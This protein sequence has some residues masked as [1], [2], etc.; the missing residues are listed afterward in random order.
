MSKSLIYNNLL[1]D[2]TSI[3]HEYN[4]I[5]RHYKLE[6]FIENENIPASAVL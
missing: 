5:I 6:K 2:F 4:I 3:K 1:P